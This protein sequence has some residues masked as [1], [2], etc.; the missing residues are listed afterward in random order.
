MYIVSV[1]LL[2]RGKAR[3]I[4]KKVS[5]TT[6]PI[7]K[8]VNCPVVYLDVKS[9]S[10]R[11]DHKSNGRGTIACDWGERYLRFHLIKQS[12][13]NIEVGSCKIHFHLIFG[14]LDF[15]SHGKRLCNEYSFKHALTIDKVTTPFL[16]VPLETDPVKVTTLIAT[17]TFAVSGNLE[18]RT[19]GLVGPQP[20]AVMS[21]GWCPGQR[22]CPFQDCCSSISVARTTQNTAAP[23]IL[24]ARLFG[25]S[26][27]VPREVHSEQVWVFLSWFVVLSQCWYCGLNSHQRTPRASQKFPLSD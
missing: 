3:L 8:D 4:W 20:M 19:W 6:T 15:W 5:K 23:H 7:F 9:N 17:H 25:Q 24:W 2:L 1:H 26:H 18:Q 21:C 12:I 22:I 13:M 14:S 11:R 16:P 10:K 27:G